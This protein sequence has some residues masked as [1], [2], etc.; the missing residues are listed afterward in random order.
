MYFTLQAD[1]RICVPVPLYHCFGMVCG[2][3]QNAVTGATCVYP[4]ESFDPAA[5]MKSIQDER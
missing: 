4:S 1:T 2:S 3:L 5:C